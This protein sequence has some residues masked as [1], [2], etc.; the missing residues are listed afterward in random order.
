MDILQAKHY[1]TEALIAANDTF[2]ALGTSITDDV[3]TNQF[4][5][6]AIRIDIDAETA[7]I[8]YLAAKNINFVLRSEEHGNLPAARPAEPAVLATLDGL[9]GSS[10]FK[11]DPKRSWAGCMFALF[12]GGN[13]RY[14]DYQ[15]AGIVHHN[16]H[17]IVIAAKG[18]GVQVI[19][20]PS[21]AEH[22]L[23]SPDKPSPTLPVCV[24]LPNFTADDPIAAYGALEQ[25]LD[26]IC[27][28]LGYTTTCSGSTAEDFTRHLLGQSQAVVEGTRKG[29]LEFATAYALIHEAGGVFLDIETGQDIGEKRFLQYGQSTHRPI[30]ASRDSSAAKRIA[31]EIFGR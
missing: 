19:D 1:V 28:S 18:Q 7:V 25:T 23:P 21:R 16:A 29:N 4:G 10:A 17:M 20:I 30:A 6:T 2:H 11:K 22:S 8:D 24:D 14:A 26:G 31:K 27:R 5:D 12:D 9:D 15:A 3:T 13:P